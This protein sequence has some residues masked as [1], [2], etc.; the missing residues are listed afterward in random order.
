MP[1]PAARFTAQIIATFGRHAEVRDAQGNVWKAR[2]MGRK[3][4]QVCG[5]EVL[6]ERNPHND[7][8]LIVELLPRRTVLARA[9]TRGDTENIV[10]NA[11][12]LAV[13]AAPVPEADFFVVD[14]YLAAAESAGCAALI[15]ANKCDLDNFGALQPALGVYRGLGY[16]V[17]STSKQ[18]VA[19]SSALR[20]A[21]GTHTAV[22]VGQSGVGKSSLIAQ[23]VPQ[24]SLSAGELT[25]DDEGRHTTT[26]SR[27]YDLTGGGSLIDSPGVRD[28]A[29]AV[30]ALEPRSLGF[31][32]IEQR[33]AA[34]RFADCQHIQ[35]PNCAVR[36][37]VTHNLM[38]A[39]RYE[40]YRRLRRLHE[41]LR[42]SLRERSHR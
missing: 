21:I 12:L 15:V 31:R 30:A 20:D 3:L 40:S 42:Q 34:C 10:A 19:Q 5:D 13:V 35:E 25:R 17:V 33:A 8:T 1:E 26:A 22:F 14:R 27:L 39:R 32:E 38:D 18:I 37:A 7:E 36:E 29:P 28:Y 9:N 2:P 6:C 4:G 16:P 23:L 41:T 11:S 24:A